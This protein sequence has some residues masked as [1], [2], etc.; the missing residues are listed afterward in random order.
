MANDLRPGELGQ[1]GAADAVTEDPPVRPVGVEPP[2]VPVADSVLGLI[3]VAVLRPLVGELPHVVVQG[4]EDL[5]GHHPLVVGRPSPHDRDHPG[6]D[7]FGVR[8][9][10]AA[11]LDGQRSR[12]YV[13]MRSLRG[14]NAKAVLARVI[15][16]VRGWTAYYQGVVSKKIFT[17]LDHHMWKLT[18]KWAK[19]SHSNKPKY[20]ISNRYFGRFNPDRADRWV[21]GD[22][23]SGAHLPKFAWTKIVRHVMVSG[24]SS[25]DDPALAQYWAD[26]R[27][28]VKLPLDNSTLRLMKTQDGQCPLCGDYLL[29]ADR[30]PASP[31]EW[32]QWLT[33]TRTAITR[34]NLVTTHGRPGNSDDVRVRL[35]QAARQRSGQEERHF[36][37]SASPFGACLSRVQRRV[38]R[39]VLSLDPRDGL[40]Q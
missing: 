12:L 31:R 8:A 1:V 30:E 11:H 26:R 22:R 36:R 4:S 39:T 15:P 35:L 28:K 13:E 20:W 19:Y 6:E 9:A 27:R 37:R 38:A 2:E 18:Y 16:I 5:L 7:C 10:Q 23:V 34:H 3:R 32:E 33:G 24:R 21:F 25:P 29:H 14:S 17:S 40:F